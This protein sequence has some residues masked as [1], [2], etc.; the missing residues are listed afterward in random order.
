MLPSEQGIA[1]GERPA[2]MR[3]DAVT[4]KPVSRIRSKDYEKLKDGRFK[5]TDPQVDFL[6]SNGQLLRITGK[7]G[8]IILQ[9]GLARGNASAAASDFNKTPRS[10]DLQDVTVE[11]FPSLN[12][13]RATTT[14]TM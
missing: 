5:V 11:I 2:W 3:Y 8:F 1:P 12:A 7:E 13:T 14:M 10:G 4:G 6:L 9:E